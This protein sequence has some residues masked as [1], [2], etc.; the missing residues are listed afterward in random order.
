[1]NAVNNIGPLIRI[2]RLQKNWSLETL[3]NGICSVSYLSKIEHGNVETNH[4][5]IEDLF[6]KLGF[7]WSE[8]PAHNLLCEQLYEG[9]FSWDD[10]YTKTQFDLLEKIWPTQAM[11]P[12]YVDF[13][14]IRAY[15]LGKLEIMPNTFLSSLD[16]RQKALYLLLQ[17]NHREAYQIYPCPLTA[18]CVAE[19]AYMEGNYIQALEYL[20]IARNEAAREGY[21]YLQLYTENY[22]ANC[23]SDM[24]NIE[25]M[26]RHS[27]I[28]IRLAHALGKKDIV[29]TI[30]YNL[31]ATQLE[32]G[33]YEVAYQYFS[34]LDSPDVM[35]LH[36]LAIS[37]ECLGRYAEAKVALDKTELMDITLMQKKMLELVRYRLENPEYLQDP[38][39][40]NLLLNTFE[41][42]KEHYH[43][44]YV[45]F[46]LRWVTQWLTANRQYRKA[47]ELLTC[48]PNY[49][50]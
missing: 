2:L 22:I 6:R 44:G 45:R 32:Q 49:N 31:A 20:Q 40:G 35:E 46:H 19:E 12:C 1:M 47:Y 14:V 41:D 13:L 25:V 11:G 26:H 4:Q 38:Y 33:N 39:Y 43:A 37:C 9:I 18:F 50:G 48:F 29:R 3:A 7:F 24:G 27:R 34:N 5:L 30:E 36:K 21:V 10:V 28:A 42:I 23:Y 8:D 15:I 17:N 16:N